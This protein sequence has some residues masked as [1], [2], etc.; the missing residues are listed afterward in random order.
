MSKIISIDWQC[1]GQNCV[2]WTGGA[3]LNAT[4]KNVNECFRS[5]RSNGWTRAVVG[6][7]RL[8]LCPKCTRARNQKGKQ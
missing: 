5:A 6:G 4:A 1:D 3:V 8:D 2:N 7:K